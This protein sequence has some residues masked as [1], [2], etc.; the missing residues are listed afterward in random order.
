MK[1]A[2][3]DARSVQDEAG[4]WSTAVASADVDLGR[5]SLDQCPPVRGAP[6]TQGRALAAVEERGD[7]P[8]FHRQRAVTDRVHARVFAVK[9]PGGDPAPNGEPIESEITKLRLFDDAFLP[10]SPSRDPKRDRI[11]SLSATIFTRF[12]HTPRLAGKGA[13]LAR[14]VC[15]KRGVGCARGNR[16]RGHV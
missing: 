9:P 12:G 2:V 8:P 7:E 15:R 4:P 5:W 3:E 1:D 11:V 6:M 13:H 16:P 14:P 10:L